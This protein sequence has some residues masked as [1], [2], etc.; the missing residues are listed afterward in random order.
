VFLLHVNVEVLFVVERL[1]AD[2]TFERPVAIVHQRVPSQVALLGELRPTHVTY[3]PMT[4]V[5]RQLAQ[6]QM[7]AQV[8]TETEPFAAYVTFERPQMV[9]S[10][11]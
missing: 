11:V 4:I 10:S 6:L 7:V 9:F 3:V 1:F 8:T 2:V 5:D